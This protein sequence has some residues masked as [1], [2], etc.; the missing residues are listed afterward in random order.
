MGIMAN[1][2]RN[3]NLVTS[4][5]RGWC[6][7]LYA[8]VSSVQSV[9]IEGYPM[10]VFFTQAAA[11]NEDG[12]LLLNDNGF[13][14]VDL[15]GDKVVGDPNPDWRGGLGF[16][17]AY[18][19]LALNCLFETSQG[20]DFSERT[21][22]ILG[23]FGTHADVGNEIT[24]TQ[25]LVNYAGVTIPAG[26]TVRGNIRNFG[27]GDVLLDESYYTTV[28]GFGDGVLNEF[29]VADGSW[30]RLREL[31][32]SYT[33]DSEGFRKSTGL[34]SIELTASGRNLKIWTDIVGADPDIN[35]FGVGQGQGLD[36]FTNPGAKS[37][38]FGLKI[39]Y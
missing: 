36:Y 15:T 2:N 7:Q 8:S 34:S 1:F 39:N 17:L 5:N 26:T 11:R 25:D 23:Y 10:G 31:S 30:T 16:N 19:G 9:A 24:L 29:T 38:V 27:G 6:R 33:L 22:F 3:R 20:N 37:F 18:K 13:P 14:M 21:R 35:Q 28:Q 4:P 12:S 32:L